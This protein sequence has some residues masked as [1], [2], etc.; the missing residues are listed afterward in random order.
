MLILVRHL[1]KTFIPKVETRQNRAV[2][3][4]GLQ[5]GRAP[6][7]DQNPGKIGKVIQVM[8]KAFLNNTKWMVYTYI[9][10]Y[11]NTYTYTYI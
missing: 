9:Y 10:T 4:S 11:I 3:F 5:M 8:S 6:R 2:P 7:L 1:R